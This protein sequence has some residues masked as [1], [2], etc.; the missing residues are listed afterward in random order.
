MRLLE[1]SQ[2]F[3]LRKYVTV[4]RPWIQ[5]YVLHTVHACIRTCMHV[6]ILYVLWY[7]CVRAM[8][9]A[10]C[11]CVLIHVH[12]HYSNHCSPLPDDRCHFSTLRGV[13][14]SGSTQQFQVNAVL[15]ATHSSVHTSYTLCAYCAYHICIP[16]THCVHTVHNYVSV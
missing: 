4:H 6:I 11:E 14:V 15:H 7:V 10:V 12:V 2:N 9:Y 13:Y 5:A 1:E 16:H 8:Q 3:H